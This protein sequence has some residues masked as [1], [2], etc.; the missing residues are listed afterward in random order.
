[1]LEELNHLEMVLR[2]AAP[3]TAPTHSLLVPEVPS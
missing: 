2:E 3:T 1:V